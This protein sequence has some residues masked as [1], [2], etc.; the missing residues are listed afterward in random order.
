M[1]T[2]VIEALSLNYGKYYGFQEYLLNI[3]RYFKKHRLDIQADRVVIACKNVDRKVFE[4]FAPELEIQALLVKNTLHRYYVLN[5]LGK[6]MNL[7][8]DDIILF[9]NNYSALTRQCKHILVIHDLLYLRKEYMPNR[10]FRLQRNL[11][12]P[13]S[14]KI[15]DKVIAISKWVKQ[16][17]EEQFNVKAPNKVIAIYNYFDF[18]KFYKGEPSQKIIDLCKG[19]DYFL[20][21]CS[22]AV[23]KNT[24]TTL[25]AYD[26]YIRRGGTKDLLVIGGLDDY[27]LDIISEFDISVRNHILSCCHVS[28]SD[29]CHIYQHASAYIS[30][31]LFEGLGMPIVEALFFGIPCIVS[32][33]PVIKEVTLGHASFFYPLDYEALCTL[34][35]QAT[36]P[37]QRTETMYI[38]DIYS[39]DNTVKR[40]ICDVINPLFQK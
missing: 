30:A 11:F 1:R 16:D 17:I 33:I 34:M 5:T 15:A 37:H 25:K 40:Y 12:V 35:E 18:N 21:V 24:V 38:K 39:T 26:E 36:I 32:D 7:D 4:A 10:A 2:L 31:T 22:G 14:V 27:L 20:V 3:L 28:N 23:H 19:R 29:L 13:R 9:T 8:K 6:R